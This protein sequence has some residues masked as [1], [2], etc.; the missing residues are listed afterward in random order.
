MENNK[1]SM[2]CD[3]CKKEYFVSNYDY[4]HMIEHKTHCCSKECCDKLKIGKQKVERIS[5][6]C[7]FCK[8]EFLVAPFEYKQKLE[9][10]LF[11]SCSK[12]CSQK[13]M[14]ELHRGK[15]SSR[16]NSSINICVYC[17]KEYL[18]NGYKKNTSKYCSRECLGKAKTEKATIKLNCQFCGKEFF[19]LKGQLAFWKELKYC[20]KECRGKASQKRVY[21]KCIICGKE[22]WQHLAYSKT[23]VTCSRKCQ[24]L[25]LSQY[26]C[27]RPEVI[28][29]L[30]KQGTKSQLNSKT[31]YTLPELLVLK[32][33]ED[34]K[35][36]FI[37]QFSVGNILVVDFLLPKYNCVLEVYGDYWHSNPRKYGKDKRPLSEMQLKNKQ[38]DIRRYKVITKKYNYYFYSLWEYDIKNNLED[39]MNGF[40][41]Y[42]N[43]K[44]RNEYVVQQ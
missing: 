10:E 29:K 7:D 30:R 17:G 25:W 37:P 19:V 41:K 23:S 15:N 34:N 18:V 13:L 32:Y 40:F 43:S 31:E 3:F 6:V 11:I 22:Y 33:L 42:I 5:L 24:K 35:I 27:R 28:E 36:E 20:S 9:N 21:F 26:Y 39:S 12:K 1:N 8:K 4:N 2:I 14:G 38:K 16:Y 44:I